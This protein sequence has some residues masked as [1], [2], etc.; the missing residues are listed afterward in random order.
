LERIIYYYNGHDATATARHCGISRK[1]FYKWFA[2]FDQDNIYSLYRLQDKSRA[3]KKN[4]QREITPIQEQRIIKIRKQHI[5]W[6]KEKLAI[7][8]KDEYQ[9]K[10]S[11]WKIQKVIE[12]WKLYYHPQKA[13]KNRLKRKKNKKKKRIT[14]LKLDKKYWFQKKAGYI[15]CLD[16]VETRW[17]SLKSIFLLPWINMEKWLAL[18][19]IKT[20]VQKMVKIFY[21]DCISF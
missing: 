4:R 13:C 15:I 6:D 8:Y 2:K 7:V 17:N 5:R 14:E 21:T 3:P 16:T 20:K 11:S 18:E 12:D 1:T 10:I 9:E 19:C